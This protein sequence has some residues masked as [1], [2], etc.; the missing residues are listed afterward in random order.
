MVAGRR[1]SW[2]RAAGT[3]LLLL[4]SG[5][6]GVARET[7]EA[8]ELHALLAKAGQYIVGYGEAFS[9]LAAKERYHQSFEGTDSQP[10]ARRTTVGA[11]CSG[12]YWTSV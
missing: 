1:W 4:A 6:T 5:S 11:P 2:G 12:V 7:R 9:Y 3:G 10:G 8:P